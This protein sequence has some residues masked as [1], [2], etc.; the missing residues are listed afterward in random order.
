MSLRNQNDKTTSPNEN[1]HN[2]PQEVAQTRTVDSFT[3]AQPSSLDDTGSRHLADN[4]IAN[5]DNNSIS[6]A[7]T[8]AAAQGIDPTPVI[9]DH[10]TQD[11]DHADN[12]S[13]AGD[14]ATSSAPTTEANNPRTAAAGIRNYQPNNTFLAP[15]GTHLAADSDT[16]ETRSLFTTEADQA[17]TTAGVI[18]HYQPNNHFNDDA[19]DSNIQF[20]LDSDSISASSPDIYRG[21]T[22]TT[23]ANRSAAHQ[24]SRP[25]QVNT[26]SNQGSTGLHADHTTTPP[27]ASQQEVS[28]PQHNLQT[29]SNSSSF[30][31]SNNLANLIQITTPEEQRRS[32]EMWQDH[33]IA[34]TGA[35]N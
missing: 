20:E 18:G 2:Q 16:S 32:I 22:P 33:I 4:I 35:L 26:G 25:A 19:T 17:S 14:S 3:A 21:A 5:Q 24:I 7:L 23:D 28:M 9:S 27:T 10:I 11:T 13:D 34:P 29:T 31:N 12:N 30:F 6:P 15:V 1:L 8:T